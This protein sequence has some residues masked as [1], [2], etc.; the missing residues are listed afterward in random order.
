MRRDLLKLVRI[1]DLS[2]KVASKIPSHYPIHSI[3]TSSFPYPYSYPNPY[4]IL[5]KA[6]DVHQGVVVAV[7]DLQLPGG[8][9]ERLLQRGRVLACH[10]GVLA[11]A[12][13]GR[14]GEVMGAKRGGRGSSRHE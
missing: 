7:F 11:L 5:E 10:D 13:V 12:G 1:L 8:E 4:R 6:G 3:L 9:H 2:G 14:G